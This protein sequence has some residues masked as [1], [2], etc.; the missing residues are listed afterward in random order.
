MFDIPWK[1]FLLFAPLFTKYWRQCMP[2]FWYWCWR[3]PA[4]RGPTPTSAAATT[5]PATP[6]TTPP[7][8]TTTTTWGEWPGPCSGKVYRYWADMLRGWDVITNIHFPSRSHNRGGGPGRRAVSNRY[9]G[10]VESTAV[11]YC[12]MIIMKTWITNINWSNQLFVSD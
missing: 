8:P 1:H 6:A 11:W 12:E 2:Y 3:P 4:W 5:A 10:Q 9:R 7:P